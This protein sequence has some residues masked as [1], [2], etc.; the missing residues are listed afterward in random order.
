MRILLISTVFFL[1]VSCFGVSMEVSEAHADE[2]ELLERKLEYLKAKQQLDLELDIVTAKI[3]KLNSE[4]S[5]IIESAASPSTTAES[6][7]TTVENTEHQEPSPEQ[8]VEREWSVT[9][10]D[11]GRCYGWK[12]VGLQIANDG[13]FSMKAKN[14]NDGWW[15]EYEGNLEQQEARVTKDG[16]Y[17]QENSSL[18]TTLAEFQSVK[19]DGVWLVELKHVWPGGGCKIEFHIE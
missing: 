1:G 6:A 2:I 14:V 17:T 16:S 19:K 11:A 10:L 12:V 4:Y 5:D 18:S 9:E 13:T 7:P 15:G 3:E 8:S